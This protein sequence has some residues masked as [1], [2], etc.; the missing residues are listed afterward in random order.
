MSASRAPAAPTGP[1]RTKNSHLQCVVLFPD[2]D[3]KIFAASPRLGLSKIGAEIGAYRADHSNPHIGLKLSFPRGEGQKSNEDAGFGVVYGWDGKAEA[4]LPS[5]EYAIGIEFSRQQG[6]VDLSIEDATDYVKSHF[7]AWSNKSEAWTMVRVTLSTSASV[8]GWGLPF[9]NLDDP[10]VHGWVAKNQPF[11]NGM[12][13]RD[14]IGQHHFKMLVP[15]LLV[16]VQRQLDAETLPPPELYPYDTSFTWAKPE[17]LQRLQRQ[18][19]S[20]QGPAF[21]PARFSYR[22]IDEFMVSGAHACL[23]DIMWLYEAAKSIEE[24][25]VFGYLADGADAPRDNERYVI[26][27]LPQKKRD[28]WE[29][30][31]NRLT[32]SQAPFKLLLFALWDDSKPA[33]IWDC[34]IVSHPQTI[35]A[36]DNFQLTDDELVLLVRVPRDAAGNPGYSWRRYESHF[37]ACTAYEDK[38]KVEQ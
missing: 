22:H 24:E 28:E 19:H 11:D 31:W 10:Q 25:R 38:D 35:E 9:A 16:H 29:Q 37:D 30:A 33:G 26:I 23:Q 15:K 27:S 6:D 36:L 20:N 3:T 8:K 4:L 32:R 34:K 7:P 5:D 18:L 21:D 2:D 14:V 12:T 13:L 17:E 1:I